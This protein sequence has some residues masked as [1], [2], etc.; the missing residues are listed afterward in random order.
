MKKYKTIISLLLC[1]VVAVSAAACNKAEL[2]DEKQQINTVEGTVKPDQSSGD[3]EPGCFLY[4]ASVPVTAGI[5]SSEGAPVYSYVKISGLS[6][7]KLQDSVNFM[8]S[9]LAG[10]LATRTLPSYPALSIYTEEDLAGAEL[11]VLADL[12][13]ACN[14]ILS[15]T[16]KKTFG[17][18]LFSC[19]EFAA[20]TVD[21]RTG[22]TLKLSDI[23]ADGYDYKSVIDAAVAGALAEGSYTA[24][25]AASA[26]EDDTVTA[27]SLFEGVGEDSCFYLDR[28]G[29][30]LVFDCNT[31]GLE[32]EGTGPVSVT[33]GF[34]AFGE[35]LLLGG[36]CD[37]LLYT[38]PQNSYS[39]L[40]PQGGL[41]CSEYSGSKDLGYD[42]LLISESFSYPEGSPSQVADAINAFFAAY[43]PD[44]ESLG[45]K[46]K[47]SPLEWLLWNRSAVCTRMGD[48]YMLVCEF[49]DNV[50]N[51]Y[52]E[53]IREQHLFAH[54]GKELALSDIFAEGFDYKALIT[55][56][57][58]D[59]LASSYSRYTL[60]E[61]ISG[62]SLYDG[63][64]SFRAGYDA[65]YIDTAPVLM[66]AEGSN[67]KTTSFSSSVSVTVNY[68]DLEKGTLTIFPGP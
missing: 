61:G 4:A 58:D 23:F 27:G 35:N 24:L 57:L 9:E 60:P 51:S 49:T 2:S 8:V 6:D 34:G 59:A 22:N 63:G 55:Q 19:G 45:A 36:G 26:D 31:P 43:V 66:S 62:S 38:D 21:L 68:Y 25:C 28:N 67:G 7:E 53:T 48:Y 11:N 44:E 40:I 65:L 15:F 56:K 50:N 20:L 52:W 29:V 39:V 14:D 30:N 17:T 47:K 5:L 32:F 1:L 18:T 10:G 64:I 37:S 33:E 3:R 54:D 46:A 41:K 16:A 13:F 12:S 42:N